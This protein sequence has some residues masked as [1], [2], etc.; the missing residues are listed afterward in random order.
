MICDVGQ[1]TGIRHHPYIE[2]EL[3]RINAFACLPDALNKCRRAA[4]NKSL[5][6]AQLQ[7]AQQ[8]EEEINGHCAV[9]ARELYF[10]T[11]SQYGNREI[12]GETHQVMRLPVR[13]RESQ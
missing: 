12:A 6:E 2:E 7:N 3:D 5:R 9:N 1:V 13:E 11:R 10:Q 8:D 4:D